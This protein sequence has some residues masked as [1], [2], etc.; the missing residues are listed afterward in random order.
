MKGTTMAVLF[1]VSTM[2]AAH[3]QTMS[4]GGY[5]LTVLD[6][7]GGPRGGHDYGATVSAAGKTI[8]GFYQ[9]D[10]SPSHVESRSLAKGRSSWR[11]VSTAPGSR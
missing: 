8:A 2:G 4:A 5:A 10:A 7:L 1:V 6:D 9:R 11:T 3:A